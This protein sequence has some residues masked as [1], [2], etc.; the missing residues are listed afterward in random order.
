MTVIGAMVALKERASSRP[1]PFL[2]GPERV[3][4]VTAALGISAIAISGTWLT[5]LP[6][7]YPNSGLEWWSLAM[8]FAVVEIFVV[9]LHFRRDA[10]SFSLSELPLAIGLFFLTPVQL[11]T[12]QLI[13]AGTALWLHRR[14]PFLKLAFNLANLA[15]SASIAV[16]LFRSILGVAEP[17][18][19]SGWIATFAAAL[20]S[21]LL[22][23]V[24]IVVAISLSLGRPRDV[25]RLFGTGVA[26]TLVNTSLALLA[27][28]VISKYPAV[29]WLL[30]V[31]AAVLFLGYRAYGSLR[32]KH[33]SLELLYASTKAI[34]QSL[35][36][37]SVTRAILEQV[38]PMFR[39]EIA[40]IV[41]FSAEPG[42]AIVNR[43]GP[44][45]TGISVETVELDPTEIGRAHV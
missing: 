33:E 37:E 4:L 25:R 19:P 23:L 15:F 10:H 38:R 41:L 28:T 14:Q 16:L 7:L 35:E 31:L 32:Q 5:P 26:A 18:G 29:S 13:G 24:F 43:L 39:S 22:T 21:D 6:A 3:W 11:I 30:F 12:A 36:V 2:R 44:G 1:I 42:S 34:Q 20:A 8:A 9:Q 27:V 45:E 17:L 40:E